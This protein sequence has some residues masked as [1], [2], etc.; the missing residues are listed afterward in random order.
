MLFTKLNAAW[1]S[2][3]AGQ[4]KSGIVTAA[5]DMAAAM[6]LSIAVKGVVKVVQVAADAVMK[7]ST[8]I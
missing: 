6:V 8:K 3:F 4:V 2:D 5:I 1:K 7:E